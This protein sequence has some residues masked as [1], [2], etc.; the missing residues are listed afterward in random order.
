VKKWQSTDH[1]ADPRFEW[2][3]DDGAVVETG[4]GTAFGWYEFWV[5]LAD[6]T[7]EYQ[8]LPEFASEEIG[9][10]EEDP[11]YAELSLG[12]ESRPWSESKYIQCITDLKRERVKHVET[13]GP[14]TEVWEAVRNHIARSRAV[15]DLKQA[16][17]HKAAHV[18]YE[19]GDLT[20]VWVPTTVI[21]TEAEEHGIET[22][23]LH[24]EVVARGADS[25]EL[26]GERIAE[27]KRAGT[28]TLRFWRLDATHGEVPE[29]DGS[30]T[31]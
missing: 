31:S 22:D 11:R 21:N 24:S 3:F 8:L 7:D 16:I 30:S 18:T 9:N 25:D 1:H 13:V 2:E 5:K 4:S 14:R 17:D 26:G 15:T 10:P 29:P 27:A 23:G 12:P 28:T 19:D 20:E 6:A